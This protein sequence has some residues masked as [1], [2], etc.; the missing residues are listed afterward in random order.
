MEPNGGNLY[1]SHALQIDSGTFWRC[2]HGRTGYGAGMK[3]VGCAECASDDP[4]AKATFDGG[5]TAEMP[6]EPTEA[7]LNAARDWSQAKYGKPIGNDA[8]IGCWKV[9]FDSSAS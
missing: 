8:A 6:R 5:P 2:A 4:A 3:W 9:M 7:M 1:M